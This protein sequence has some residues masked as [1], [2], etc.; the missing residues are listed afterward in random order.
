MQK[1]DTKETESVD[2]STKPMLSL[3]RLLPSRKI[4]CAV[5]REMPT[6]PPLVGMLL[7]DIIRHCEKAFGWTE[8]EVQ[9]ALAWVSMEIECP[10]DEVRADEVRCEVLQ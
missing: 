2:T 10:S 5:F 3:R 4:Q 8:Q 7:A 9:A 6:R 1:S